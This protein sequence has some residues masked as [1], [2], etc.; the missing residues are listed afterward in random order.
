MPATMHIWYEVSHI[1][2]VSTAWSLCGEPIPYDAAV[3]GL[4]H[5]HHAHDADIIED[6]GRR[7]CRHCL[8]HWVPLSDR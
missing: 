2:Q 6:R 4:D 7:I 5:L 3:T 1:D 8:D